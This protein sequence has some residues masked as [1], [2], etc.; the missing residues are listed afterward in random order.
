[1][2]YY[3]ITKILTIIGLLFNFGNAQ[4]QGFVFNDSI[5]AQF[6]TLENVKI[7]KDILPKSYSLKKY[8]P[9]VHL[10]LGSECVAYSFSSARTIL[11]AIEQ[12]WT[13]QKV[14]SN[15][16]FSPFHIYFRNKDKYDLECNKG[17]N[18]IAVANDLMENGVPQIKSVE[19]PDYY[20]CNLKLRLC[21]YYPPN[22]ANDLVEGRQYLMKI[23]RAS[24]IQQIKSSIFNKNPVVV[25]MRIP[26]SAFHDA[27][28]R[29]VPK[30]TDKYEKE[31][32][33]AM[34]VVSYDDVKF[35]GAFQLLNSWG[36]D[37]GE[38]GY[39]WI[40]YNDFINFT[41][42]ALTV[43]SPEKKYG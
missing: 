10:Q 19:C 9:Y 7:T 16:S 41:L 2:K 42:E 20:P 14:I 28:E 32:G 43:S 33:H 22:Y 13:D 36:A 21:N 3:Q 17:L 39:T 24:N 12:N 26:D 4:S 1:M 25:G 18:P 40:S 8:A 5:K 23:E 30:S 11:Y 6:Q 35:G 27:K 38:N 29:W 15:N 34:V 31:M 37:W